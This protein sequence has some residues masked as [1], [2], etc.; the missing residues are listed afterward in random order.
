MPTHKDFVSENE[1]KWCPGCGDYAILLSL[2]KALAQL[3]IPNEKVVCVSG[4]GCAGRMPYYLNTFGF[5]TLH[6]RAPA[7]ATGLSMV[8]DDLSIWVIVGD[9]DGLSIGLNHL[10]H[11]IRRNIKVN[12]LL[13]NNQIYG[14]TKGQ[15]SPTSKLGQKTKTSI[16][17][18]RDESLNPLAIALASG[19]GFVARGIDKNPKQLTE[20][21]IEAENYQGCSFIEIYQNCNVFNDGTFDAFAEKNNRSSQTIDLIDKALLVTKDNTW[22][23]SLGENGLES[24]DNASAFINHNETSFN[25]AMMLATVVYPHAPMPLGIFYRKATTKNETPKTQFANENALLSLFQ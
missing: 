4:I 1:V 25:Q 11:A 13:I 22:G 16:S 7:C 2:Q 20:L 24:S 23:L 10:V 5:H 3:A 18:V 12:V 9:G 17:G 19:A 6:G 15:A 14:L 8:R 21:F